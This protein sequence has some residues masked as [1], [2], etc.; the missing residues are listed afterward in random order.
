ML[1]LMS[2]EQW[3]TTV[4]MVCYFFTVIGAALTIFIARR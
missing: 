2:P 1:P 3:T 4:E